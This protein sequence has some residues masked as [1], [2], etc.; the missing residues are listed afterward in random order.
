VEGGE[1]L[2]VV[3]FRTPFNQLNGEHSSYKNLAAYG[4][5]G[6]DPQNGKGEMRTR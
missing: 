5:P 4:E 6:G 2:W 3:S 1:G